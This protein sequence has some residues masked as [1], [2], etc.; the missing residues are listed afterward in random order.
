MA[1]EGCTLRE[2]THG[3]NTLNLTDVQ[4]HVE[5][6]ARQAGDILKSHLGKTTASTKSSAYDM[7]T[8]ADRASE[9]MLSEALLKAYPEHHIVGEEG[10]GYGVPLAEAEY[11]WYVDP[12][13]GTTNFAAGLPF[14]AVSIALAD[15]N[16]NPL[17][18][19]VYNPV[20]DELFSASKGNGTTLN[21]QPI[22]VSTTPELGQS[23][24]ASGFP[25]DKWTSEEN[26]GREWVALMRQTRGIRRLGSAALDLCYVAAGRFDAYWEQ[27]LHSWDLMAGALCVLEAGGKITDYEGVNATQA[28]RSGRLVATNGRVHDALLQALQ[29]ARAAMPLT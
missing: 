2:Q 6:L 29:T 15:R 5:Q 8:E 19:V 21:G 1:A 16:M 17:V 27:K 10:G 11:V 24:V 22:H 26:N 14:F 25:Y 18:G 7:V 13:D 12:L 20:M 28:F 4:H 3:D 23:L 9:A